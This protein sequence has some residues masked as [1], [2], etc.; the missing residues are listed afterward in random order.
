MDRPPSPV[1]SSHPEQIIPLW[2]ILCACP[3]S[4]LKASL[5]NP[6]LNLI[7]FFRRRSVKSWSKAATHA[8]TR[9]R[10]DRAEEAP[11]F[12]SPSAV[13][14]RFLSAACVAPSFAVQKDDK[15][16]HQ[17]LTV[18]LSSFSSSL[19]VF[20]FFSFFKRPPRYFSYRL[21]RKRRA[22]T[23]GPLLQALR[24]LCA[25]PAG[26]PPLRAGSRLLIIRRL[27]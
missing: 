17:M 20:F 24:A 4:S 12:V 18:L 14:A 25:K 6:S 19:L 23:A 16:G 15:D 9:T 26:D 3:L 2:S 27:T 7:D 13:R 10:L 5:A 8:L 22:V 11:G 1:P 21:G